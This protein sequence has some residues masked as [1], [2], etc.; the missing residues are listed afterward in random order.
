MHLRNTVYYNHQVVVYRMGG[1]GQ[2]IA[3]RVTEMAAGT[4]LLREGHTKQKMH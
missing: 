1:L 4:P 3:V 2:I